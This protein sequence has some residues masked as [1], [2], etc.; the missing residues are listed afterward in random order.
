MPKISII[1]P[2][3][4]IENYITRCITSILSQSFFDYELILI[5]DGSSD[6]SGIIC[7]RF[8]IGD[9]RIHVIHQKNK[10][11]SVARNIGILFATGDY[12]TF[13]DGDD[14]ISNNFVERLYNACK[15]AKAQF[16]ICDIF[17][18]HE[19]IQLDSSFQNIQLFS[20]EAAINYFGEL[21][22]VRFRSPFGKLVYSTIVKEILFPVGRRYAE[23][24]ACVYKWMYAS[25]KIVDISEKLYF[26]FQRA[27][28]AVHA[29]YDWYRLDSYETFEEMLNFFSEHKIDNPF[30]SCLCKYLHEMTDGYERCILLN[31]TEIADAIQTNLEEVMKKWLNVSELREYNHREDLLPELKKIN[32]FLYERYL[33]DC[34]YGLYVLYNQVNSDYCK[35]IIKNRLVRIIRKYHLPLD[36]FSYVYEIAF[37]KRMKM[38]WLKKALFRKLKGEKIDAN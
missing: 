28:S 31:K 36:G 34:C 38:Y 17:N 22:D 5:D 33:R 11:V 30:Y 20:K 1:V 14:W 19:Q 13:V 6:N 24:M 3:Y 2:V 16:A 7:E 27:N 35:R 25:N 9:S 29:E 12:I 23:D 26:Y 32:S 37:P 4:S 21:M 10:G 15:K 18:T 8:E